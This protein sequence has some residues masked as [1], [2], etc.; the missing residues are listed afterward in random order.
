MVVKALLR[1]LV[2]STGS[3]RGKK[4][5]F[6]KRFTFQLDDG[7]FQLGLGY[8][9]MQLSPNNFQWYMITRGG[10]RSALTIFDEY[11]DAL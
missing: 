7:L 6:F 1:P 10:N 5:V 4:L 2:W 11:R 9:K 8:S 3:S